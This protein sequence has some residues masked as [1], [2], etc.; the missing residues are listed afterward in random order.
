MQRAAVRQLD[1]IAVLAD[2]QRR[3]LYDLVRSSQV[4]LTREQCAHGLD[5]SRK[6]AAF[7]LD[8]L[9]AVGLLEPAERPESLPR[10]VGRAPKLYRTTS[11]T[12]SLSLPARCYEELALVL[13]L[14]VESQGQDE[15]PRAARLRVA[16]D[17]G[18]VRGLSHRRVA[19][20]RRAGEAVL[21]TAVDALADE[22]F[23]PYQARAGVVRL[24]NCPFHPIAGLA[25]D[26]V[27]GI[28]ERYLD[29]LLAGLGLDTLSATL[30][31][32]PGECCV[33]ISSLDT[34]AS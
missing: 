22:G 1:A 27:C 34:S 30:A 10:R 8:K 18:V 12:V 14:S 29:G 4:P 21:A 6:L 31:P 20:R 15:E 25:P 19:R 16:H 11:E 17:R 5:I 24:A 32:A 7:H 13:A 28:N 2:P 26:L 23:E 33:E 9:V 3:R